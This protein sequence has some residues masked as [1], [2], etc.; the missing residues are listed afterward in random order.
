M[1]T[2]H[3]R[4]MAVKSGN[5]VLKWTIMLAVVLGLIA[6]SSWWLFGT[7]SKAKARKACLDRRASA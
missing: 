5:T 2:K 1:A 4:R 6:G 7:K 3:A